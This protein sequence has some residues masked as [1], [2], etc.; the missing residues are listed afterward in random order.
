MG[1]AFESRDKTVASLGWGAGIFCA[2]LPGAPWQAQIGISQ[3]LLLLAQ[4]EQ[5]SEATQPS[6]R[7]KGSYL[8]RKH[9]PWGFSESCV[10]YGV[11]G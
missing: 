10:E 2:H 9:C 4:R 6:Y 11:V 3:P 5:H 8:L 7:I 1:V